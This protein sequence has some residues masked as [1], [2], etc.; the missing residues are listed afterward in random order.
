MIATWPALPDSWQDSAMEI[1]IARMQELV[2]GVREVRNR[3]M[4][5][6]KTPLELSVRCSDG[7]ARDFFLLAPFI[8]SL[9][10]VGKFEC[11]ADVKKPSQSA[12]QVNPEF[13]AYVSLKGLIDPVAEVKRLEKQLAEKTKQID[14]TR[15][16]LEN[17]QFIQ[18]AP[19]EV[20]AQQKQSIVE[21]TQQIAVIEETIRDLKQAG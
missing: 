15:K 20:V 19:A 10:G 3:Y 1:R 2:R 14:G 16:K 12:T 9:A 13:E 8:A 5:D 21:L 17:A 4:V 7:L 6:S 18:N 11:G